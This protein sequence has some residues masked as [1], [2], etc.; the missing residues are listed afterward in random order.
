MTE[1]LHQVQMEDGTEQILGNER[2]ILQFHG[3]NEISHEMRS[4][5]TREMYSI[6]RSN[7]VLTASDA[8]CVR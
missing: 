4:L 5:S 8:P 6:L 3:P 7:K 2:A 1:T